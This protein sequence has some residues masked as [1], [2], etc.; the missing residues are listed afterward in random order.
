MQKILVPTD[1]SANADNATQFAID[2][3]NKYGSEIH[4]LHSFHI[5]SKRADVMKNM[6]KAVRN[7]S[8]GEMSRAILKFKRLLGDNV[9]I[10]G[11]VMAGP[12]VSNTVYYAEKEKC[13]L[14]V[15]GTQG[16]TGALEVFI[17]STTGGVLKSAS[18]PVLAIPSQY[19]YRP[20]KDIVL[21][22][23]NQPLPSREVFSPLQELAAIYEAEVNIFH[24]RMDGEERGIDEKVYTYLEGLRVNFHEESGRSDVHERINAFVK[25]ANA[26][27]LC[28]VRRKR[29]FFE[30]LFKGSATLKQVYNSPA[31]LLVLAG[32]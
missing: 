20:L 22:L 2:I 25:E 15:M 6:G 4:L 28:M 21:A 1:F 31:P 7:E 14:I 8:E 10:S 30:S 26:S 19:G 13:T 18:V 27:L 9:S 11:E 17:G 16:A 32:D 5:S 12:A 29:G 3:A 23:D 24:L